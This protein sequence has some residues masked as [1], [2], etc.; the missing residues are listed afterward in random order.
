MEIQIEIPITGKDMLTGVLDAL[1]LDIGE[2]LAIGHD[3]AR[4]EEFVPASDSNILDI[5]KRYN[6]T[7]ALV[8]VG[9]KKA[10]NFTCQQL[11]LL[12]KHFKQDAALL[13]IPEN[14]LS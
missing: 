5:L 13:F 6:T 10:T 9:K 1:G 7:L 2:L 14:Y 11:N 12:N 3:E 4:W 8:H